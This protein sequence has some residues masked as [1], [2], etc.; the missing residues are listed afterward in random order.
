M[1]DR[2]SRVAASVLALLT[3]VSI[4]LSLGILSVPGGDTSRIA[5]LP[6]F[7]ILIGLAA[8]LPAAVWFAKLELDDVWPLAISIVLWLP[9]LPFGVPAA[10]LIWEGPIE[11]VVWG[12]VIAGL[13]AA[14]RPRLPAACSNPSIAPWIAAAMLGLASL[15]VFSHVRE[16]VPG[17]DEPHYLAAT[18][19]ILEDADLRV[20][21]N[22]ANGDYLEYFPGRLEPHFL[23]R[24][25]SGEIYSIHAPGVS[26]IVLPAFAI[27]GYAAAAITMMLI[28][29]LT[30]ALTWRI[31]YRVSASAAGAWAGVIAVFVTAPY[32]FHTFTIYPEI[33]GSLCVMCGVWL[34]VELND[35]GD[36]S[37]RALIAIGFALAVLPW[38]HSRFAVLAA[39][40]G[41]FII[42]R[43]AGRPSAV[44][45][46]TTVLIVPAVFGAAWFA[47]FHVIWGSPS[48]AAPYGADTS[49]SAS[50]IVRGLIGLSVDQQFGVVATAPVYAMALIGLRPFAKRN[51]RLTIELVV[52]AVVYAV[53]VASYAMWWAGSAAPARFLVS[54]LPLAALP[55]A[56][57][58]SDDERGAFAPLVVLLL[59]VSV[60]LVLPRAIENGGRF[61]FNNRGGVDPTLRWLSDQTDFARAVPSVHQSGGMKAGRDAMVW[62]ASVGFFGALSVRV[63]RAR[64]RGTAFAI[65]GL[66]GSI[67]VMLAATG[68]WLRHRG[69]GIFTL[70]SQHAAV[71]RFHPGWQPTILEW[72]ELTRKTPRDFLNRQSMSMA[73]DMR[74]DYVPAGEYELY[75]EPPIVAG[76][77]TMFVGRTDPALAS[78]NVDDLRDPAHPFRLRLPVMLRTLNFALRPAPRDEM[79]S[80]TLRPVGVVRA[81][82]S[83]PAYRA[84]RY[85]HARAFFLDEQAYLEPDGFW[86]RANSRA[87]VVIDT[88]EGTRLSGLPISITAGAVATTV[89]IEVGRWEETVTLAA[90]QKFDVMLPP[91][92]NGTWVLSIR[93]GAGFRPS[94]RDPASRDVRS[95]AAWIA[96]H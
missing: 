19:S 83:R 63:A 92:T 41:I 68:V 93:S 56:L 53:T 96:I 51:P 75:V 28:A 77:L 30:A 78:P 12:I 22:Y 65:T 49:T 60:S 89:T 1:L 4:W 34:L 90:G 95:L 67:A 57:V 21:N 85:G 84:G 36:V 13:I 14:N 26:V 2:R 94:E 8:V 70:R 18:Q 82:V 52:L 7:W 15:A 11:A 39:L 50:Y 16:V 74:L 40:L 91:A 87:T 72:P 42:A 3:A 33:I 44:R 37:T 73:G 64:S 9:F 6:S 46:I 59:V 31:A 79:A 58:V 80:Y 48:P 45:N 62:L 43:L 32:F 29:A 81:P 61:I 27:G 10:F 35:G 71:E 86:T 88:D 66:F 38:L 23:K 54:I 20:A 55:I 17:G 76:S 25:T 5:A 69:D 47:Y 24:S